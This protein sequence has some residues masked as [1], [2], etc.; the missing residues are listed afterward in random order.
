[1]VDLRENLSLGFILNVNL[2]HIK[3]VDNK[4]IYP[5]RKYDLNQ[6]GQTAI[7]DDFFDVGEAG[8][9]IIN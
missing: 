9:Q 4:K 5:I 6:G 2:K 7:G 8:S 1:M 3:V